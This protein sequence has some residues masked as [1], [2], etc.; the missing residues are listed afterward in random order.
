MAQKAPPSLLDYQ[1][2]KRSVVIGLVLTLLLWPA[3]VWLVSQGMGRV[4][5][6]TNFRPR[7]AAK[8]TFNIELAP[9]QFIMPKKA[10]PPTKFVETNPDA[11]ENTPDH[12]QNFAAQNQQVAQEKPTPDGK[13]DTPKLEGKKDI[14]S[15]Q[16]VSGQLTPPQQAPPPM[17]ANPE[18]KEA[19]TAE[20]ARRD[21]TPLPGFEKK[22]GDDPSAF[23]SSAAQ[24]VDSPATAVP[25]RLPGVKDAPSLV[26]APQ[27]TQ[28]H[29]DPHR[30]MPRPQLERHARPAVFRENQFGTQNIGAIAIDARW[31][32]YGQYLQKLIETVQIQWER[33][34]E[35]GRVYPPP[36]SEVVVK[37]RL[38]ATQGAVAEI[39]HSEGSA[40]NQAERACISAITE[41]SPY[42]PWTDDMKAVLGDSQELTFTF[43]YQ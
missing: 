15:N 27:V 17:P 14:E 18:I 12:T 34:I 35:Q 40:G 32:Q 4:G 8:P 3:V 39:L 37:F 41:R 2:D 29:I 1:E 21:Q 16:I 26:G 10:P 9:D 19:A 33:I 22:L 43:Y 42:G 30:P 31:S 28:Q 25:E 11:P 7:V 20:Q 13:S 36:G 24:K 5:N 6:G 38:E 23:G